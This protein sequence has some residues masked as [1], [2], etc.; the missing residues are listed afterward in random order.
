MLE[1]VEIDA[2]A[3]NDGADEVPVGMLVDGPSEF[4]AEAAD[5]VN[6][7]ATTVFFDVWPFKPP[8]IVGIS[9]R[10]REAR[11]FARDEDR[12]G[13]RSEL[14]LQLVVFHLDLS[15]SWPASMVS[16]EPVSLAKAR[17]GRSDICRRDTSPNS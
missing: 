11:R 6:V 12:Q 1:A 5:G 10:K 15:E 9:L 16:C 3:A 2:V 8:R 17:F 14:D 13:V 7:V 4:C